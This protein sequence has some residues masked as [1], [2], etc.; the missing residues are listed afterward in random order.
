MK[1]CKIKKTMFNLL[2]V[3]ALTTSSLG[4]LILLEPTTTINAA[5]AQQ[6][7]LTEQDAVKK[8][9]KQFKN[10]KVT[11]IQI[12]K[13]NNHF[14]YEVSGTDNQKEYTVDINAKT[15]KVT[16]AN[17][18][19][20][21]NGEQKTALD[22][23]KVISRKQANKIAERAVDNSKGHSWTLE[24]ENGV[25][26]WEVEVINDDQQSTEVKINAQ[27]KKVISTQADD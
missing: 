24:N 10:I 5:S 14:E 25:P 1:Q 2:A 7:K 18:E 13:K 6:I 26:V 9:N 11:E 3:T 23:S 8:F 17:S 20:L 27:T 16:N 22:L 12:E 21:D 19:Q 4:G 15:G